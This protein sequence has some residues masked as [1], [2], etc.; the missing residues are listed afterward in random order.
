MMRRFCSPRTVLLLALLH[1][2]ID[3]CLLRRAPQDLPAAPVLLLLVLLAGL[4]AS[5]LLS[6]TAGARLDLALSRAVLDLT[7]ALGVLAAALKW[8]GK[9]ARFTQT[10]TA[11]LGADTLLGLLALLPLT[12]A[13]TATGGAWLLLAAALYMALLIWSVLV[14]AHIVRHAF[15]IHWLLAACCVMIYEFFAF[16]LIGDLLPPQS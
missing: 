15:S 14:A 8:V 10:A 7:L 13:G 12:L 6:V 2:F 11:L 5:V 9:P 16:L 4:M 1:F 3:L